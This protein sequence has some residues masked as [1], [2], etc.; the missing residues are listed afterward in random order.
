M[1]L[2]SQDR[3]KQAKRPCAVWRGDCRRAVIQVLPYGVWGAKCPPGRSPRSFDGG[4]V[5]G[6]GVSGRPCDVVVGGNLARSKW[7]VAR[8]ACR[9]MAPLWWGKSGQSG[10]LMQ[11]L[12]TNDGGQPRR[13]CPAP[14][15]WLGA[16]YPCM[17]GSA[18]CPCQAR[19]PSQ[20]WSPTEYGRRL[21]SAQLD[22]CNATNMNK[23][24]MHLIHYHHNHHNQ[25]HS[26]KTNVRSLPSLNS[27]WHTYSKSLP[28]SLQ[29]R[30]TNLEPTLTPVIPQ[31]IRQ[32]HWVFGA[33]EAPTRSVNRHSKRNIKWVQTHVGPSK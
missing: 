14:S 23:G 22:H 2:R 17:A 18:A 5:G 7:S 15:P 10:Q 33:Q 4:K 11:I 31:S 1:S 3:P 21:L 6:G 26:S 16:A 28:A 20:R 32:P 29:T 12:G 8:R 25:R 24:R 27:Y 9:Q 30:G 19:H 13:P